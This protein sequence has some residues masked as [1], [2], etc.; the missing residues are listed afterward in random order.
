MQLTKTMSIKALLMGAL[1]S[2][3]GAMGQAGAQSESPLQVQASLHELISVTDAEGRRTLQAI[4]PS[5][6]VP[7]DRL[8]YTTLVRNQGAEPSDNIAVTR[9]IP[10]HTRYIAGSAAG[11]QFQISMSA[12]GGQ[13]WAPEGQLKVRNAQGQWRAATPADYTHVRWQYPAAL[14]Q[15]EARKVSFQVNVL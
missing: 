3:L 9:P 1:I 7:G 2:G 4:E 5:K 12:D 14:Q 8:L 15:N 11:A 10:P 6:V 13:T